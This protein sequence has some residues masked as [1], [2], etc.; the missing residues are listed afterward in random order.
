MHAKFL[1][2][3]LKGGD[4]LEDRGVDGRVTFKWIR[5]WRCWVDSSCPGAVMNIV[6]KRQIWQNAWY[7]LTKSTTV[8]FSRRTVLHA[9]NDLS[10]DPECL[11][12]V[13]T[14]SSTTNLSCLVKHSSLPLTCIGVI[15]KRQN[16]GK[17]DPVLN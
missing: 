11:H 3:N 17:V 6:T 5:V 7:F 4:Y 2:E 16:E 8:S 10:W 14:L 15:Y 1:S 9:V 12:A 13:A